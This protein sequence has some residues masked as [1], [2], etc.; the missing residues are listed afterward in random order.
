MDYI[1]KID[2]REKERQVKWKRELLADFEAGQDWFKLIDAKNIADI[3]H[4]PSIFWAFIFLFISGFLAYKT[5]YL[6][7]PKII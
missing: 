2:N 5:I 7:F 3:T 6:Y 4:L 1:I